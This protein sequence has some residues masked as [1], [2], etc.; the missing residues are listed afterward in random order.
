MNEMAGVDRRAELLARALEHQTSEPG[1]AR[2]QR[3]T[4]EATHP[5]DLAIRSAADFEATIRAAYGRLGKR[6]LA[7]HNIYIVPSERAGG[8]D[9]VEVFS[10]E[11]HPAISANPYLAFHIIA[12]ESGTLEFRWRGDNGFEAVETARIEVT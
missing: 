3:A 1:F 2:F 10:A 5:Q 9:I 8:P 7:S 12:I 4:N 11:L 6:E